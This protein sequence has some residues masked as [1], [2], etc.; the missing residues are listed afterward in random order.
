MTGGSDEKKLL[1]QM[2]EIDRINKKLRASGF[3]IHVLKGAEV[4]IL[5]DGLLDIDNKVLAKL[6]VVGAAVHSLF[7]LPREKQTERVIRAME[8]PHLDILFHPTGRIINR[9]KPI[10]ISME[11]IIQAA[12][13]TGTILEI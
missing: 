9:R 11:K 1:W 10:D 3:K 2:A 7:N 8:N 5:K 13:R 6:D 4:N 12:K